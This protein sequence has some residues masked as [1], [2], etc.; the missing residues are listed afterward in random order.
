MNEWF[1]KIEIVNVFFVSEF[2]LRPASLLPNEM[3][4][5]QSIL[6]LLELSTGKE[7]LVITSNCM[8]FNSMANLASG[9]KLELRVCQ[10]RK[11]FNNSLSESCNGCT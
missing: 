6:H 11:Q 1:T 7:C 8:I 5:E 4:L 10:K 3:K 9:S 2:R